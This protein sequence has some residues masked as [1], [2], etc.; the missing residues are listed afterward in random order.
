MEETKEVFKVK[1]TRKVDFHVFVWVISILAG[2]MITISGFLFEEVASL[3]TELVSESVKSEGL[4][5]ELA[6]RI[7]TERDRNQ[8]IREVLAEIKT[9]IKNIKDTVERA[10]R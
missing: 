6:A 1:S 4:N 3:R 2:A 7:E 9:D 5:K 8:S 10:R